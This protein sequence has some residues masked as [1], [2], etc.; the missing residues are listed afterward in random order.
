VR[1]R[2]TAAGIRRISQSLTDS[3]YPLAGSTVDGLEVGSEIPNQ[4]SID[5]SFT[6]YRVLEGVREVPLRVFDVTSPRDL[7]YAANDVEWSEELAG[8]IERSGR[9]DPLIVVVDSEGPYI[10]EGAHRLGA[11]SVLGKRSLPALVVV[12]EEE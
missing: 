4:D 5:A 7:F 9:I 6:D 10:L 11:L 8:E 1:F 2:I 12:E 3:M